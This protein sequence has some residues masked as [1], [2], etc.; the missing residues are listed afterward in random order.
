MANRGG[1]H[2][3][4]AGLAAA[5]AGCDALPSMPALEVRWTGRDT[6]RLESR[7][8]AFWCPGVARLEIRGVQGDAGAGLVLYAR[9]ESSAAPESGAYPVFDPLPDTGTPRPGSA[10]ALRLFTQTLIKG[11]RGDSGSVALARRG[12]TW[13]A[14]IAARLLT[15][16][17]GDTVWLTGV[18]RGVVPRVAPERCPDSLPRSESLRPGPPPE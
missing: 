3:C 4:F 10:V 6:G 11:Y 15:M 14:R 18:A 16:G 8:Q 9:S 5:L 17:G 13:S 1:P 12:R 7:A 2:L